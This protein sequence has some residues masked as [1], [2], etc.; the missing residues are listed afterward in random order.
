MKQYRY[1]E[2]DMKSQEIDYYVKLSIVKGAYEELEKEKESYRRDARIA[3]TI[4]FVL[5]LLQ[6]V[7]AFAK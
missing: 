4:L 2:D 3:H 1:T 7:A 6:I 5:C